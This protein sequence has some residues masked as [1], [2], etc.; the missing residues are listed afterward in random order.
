MVVAYT[1]IAEYVYFY[2]NGRLK[3]RSFLIDN[4]QGHSLF[5]PGGMVVRR[6]KVATFAG[7]FDS[8][9]RLASWFPTHLPDGTSIRALFIVANGR[10]G[11]NPP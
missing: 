4:C 3:A 10:S 7:S 11:Q 9:M 1:M 2:S 6:E 8:E 5:Y